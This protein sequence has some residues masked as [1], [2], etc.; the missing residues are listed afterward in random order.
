[1]NEKYL[2]DFSH[3]NTWVFETYNNIRCMCKVNRLI[4]EFVRKLFAKLEHEQV[5]DPS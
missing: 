2:V 3:F 4:G 1:M 5:L